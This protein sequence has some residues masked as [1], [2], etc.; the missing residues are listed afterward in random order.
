MP[1]IENMIGVCN[2][3]AAIAGAY[4]AKYWID[5]ARARVP[6]NEVEGKNSWPSASITGQDEDGFFDWF[7][8]LREQGRLNAKAAYGASVAASF[9]AGSTLLQVLKP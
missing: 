9:M 2:V 5:S 7:L 6:S 1:T 4:S 8:T 3:V